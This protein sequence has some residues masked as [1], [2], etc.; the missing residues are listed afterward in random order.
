MTQ[1]LHAVP[2]VPAASMTAYIAPFIRYLRAEGKDQGTIDKY[3]LAVRQLS[4]FLENP[5]VAEVTKV[6]LQEFMVQVQER[7]KSSTA[8]TKFYALRAFFNFLVEDEEIRW[9]PMEKMTPPPAP[10][11]EVPII[12][13]EV[14]SAM[15]KTCKTNSFEDRRDTAVILMLLD[16]GGRV[17][18][19]TNMTLSDVEDGAARVMGKGRKPRTVFY[20]STTARALDRYLRAR[21]RHPHAGSA[22][23]WLG[24]R[25]PMTRFG[26]RDIL[27][28][29]C[30]Q[31][32][33]ARVHPHQFRHTFAHQWL[34]GGGHET[35]L[36]RLTGWS[37]RSMLSR[38]A[39]SA[40][41]ARA[42][43]SYRRRQSPADKLK[44][45][46]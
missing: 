45:G 21:D 27:E 11:P 1:P 12:T 24:K 37:S 29:R 20:G 13:E 39:A 4:E 43:E 7:W 16:T 32:G 25:G 15:L 42:A 14:L 30:D 34:A 5:H 3:T 9:H 6:H 36:M 2:N 38:Y 8:N 44:G 33:V 23:L 31:A 17:S 22:R 40:A 35:D 26:I 10:A 18:E 28:R 46:K 19:V 41:D